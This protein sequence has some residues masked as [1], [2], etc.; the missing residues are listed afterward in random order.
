MLHHL[1]NIF[2]AWLVAIH[3]SKSRPTVA[4]LK[5]I[6]LVDPEDSEKKRHQ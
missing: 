4:G 1:V 5:E 6:F 3:F 2:A